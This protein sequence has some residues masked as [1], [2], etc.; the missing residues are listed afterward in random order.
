[1]SIDQELYMKAMADAADQVQAYARSLITGGGRADATLGMN[2]IS[3]VADAAVEKSH[4]I[5]LEASI[6]R[7]AALCAENPGTLATWVVADLEIAPPRKVPDYLL[8]IVDTYRDIRADG[9]Q[10]LEDVKTL[11]REYEDTLAA[12]VDR[13]ARIAELES[14]LAAR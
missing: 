14:Q 5:R 8:E 1:M 13:D 12:V 10:V 6:A 11:A 7:V 2:L 9:D 4:R 3:K